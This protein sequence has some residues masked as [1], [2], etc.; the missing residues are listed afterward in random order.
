MVGDARV[1][2]PLRHDIRPIGTLPILAFPEPADRDA[3]TAVAAYRTDLLV[4]L[5]SVAE[6]HRTS[7]Y[8]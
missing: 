3:A 6:I 5:G 8:I 2:A 1:P 7:P 4:K